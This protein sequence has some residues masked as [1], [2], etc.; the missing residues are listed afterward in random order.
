MCDWFNVSTSGFYAWCERQPSQR[1][2]EDE[3]WLDQI[4]AVFKD[5]RDTYGSP[6]VHA[7]LKAKGETIGKRR[8]E[9][10][11]RNNG[12]QANSTH[13]YRRIPGIGRFYKSANNRIHRLTINRPNQVWVGDVTYL[14]V[15][16]EWRYLATV[17]DRYSRKLIGWAFG[18]DKTASLTCRALR[19]AIRNRKPEP[20]TI[21][22][23]GV[24]PV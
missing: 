5:S 24:D 4:K 17:M 3:S 1:A 19:R 9:R 12:I 13:L 6:R 10:I 16:G 2:V 8:V 23:S 14:K 11:M 18:R 15:N 7:A 21:F 20:D 22:H